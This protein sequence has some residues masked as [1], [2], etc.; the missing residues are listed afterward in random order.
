[1]GEF[2]YLMNCEWLTTIDSVESINQCSVFDQGHAQAQGLVQ[3]LM[4]LGKR[5]MCMPNEPLQK[6]VLSFHYMLKIG[7][8]SPSHQSDGFVSGM[9]DYKKLIRHAQPYEKERQGLITSM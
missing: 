4:N 9:D 5:F 7:V 6:M 2:I 8:I 1:M 3:S